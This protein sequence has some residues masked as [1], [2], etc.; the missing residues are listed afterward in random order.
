MALQIEAGEG[1]SEL[2]NQMKHENVSNLLIL[3]SMQCCFSSNSFCHGQ[4][5]LEYGNYFCIV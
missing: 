4:L 3:L 2:I 5:I 1:A